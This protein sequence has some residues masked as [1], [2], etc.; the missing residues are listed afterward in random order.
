MYQYI[1]NINVLNLKSVFSKI[2]QFYRMQYLQNSMGAFTS[3]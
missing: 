1:V 3:L 2:L